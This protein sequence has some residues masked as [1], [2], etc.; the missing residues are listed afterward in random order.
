MRNRLSDSDPDE[1]LFLEEFGGKLAS[2]R[3]GDCPDPRMLP[4]L[5]EG[6]LPEREAATVSDHLEK[7]ACCRQLASQMAALPEAEATPEAM[8]RMLARIRPA[9]A[10]EKPTVRRRGVRG[11]WWWMLAPAAAALLLFVVST[12]RHEDI[13][14]SASVRTEAPPERQAPLALAALVPLEKAPIELPV[15]AM[16]TWRAEP[17]AYYNALVTALVPY[18]EGRYEEAGLK[19]AEVVKRH[20]KRVEAE[21]YLGVCD[22]MQGDAKKAVPHLEAA[23]A[24][25]DEKLQRMA[26]WYL[27]QA[28]LHAEDD[29]GARGR[30]RVLCDSAGLYQQRACSVVEKLD[31]VRKE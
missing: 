29:D 10:T 22:L 9:A 21:F 19:L 30:L 28:L 25:P 8:D 14:R 17:D 1:D 27:A 11:V 31:Q 12:G 23:A 13:P 16:L 6:V 15:E 26:D 24:A 7:C 20:P 5:A 4:A 18:K 3:A 2:L